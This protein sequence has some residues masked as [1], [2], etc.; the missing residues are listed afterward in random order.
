MTKIPVK[1]PGGTS[2][3]T[4]TIKVQDIKMN[5]NDTISNEGKLLYKIDLHEY[6]SFSRLEMRDT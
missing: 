6:F 5:C 3:R 1:I 4:F 2:S